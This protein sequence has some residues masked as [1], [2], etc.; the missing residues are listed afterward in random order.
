MYHPGSALGKKL[1]LRVEDLVNIEKP[2]S[3]Y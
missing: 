3:K 2:K 1:F